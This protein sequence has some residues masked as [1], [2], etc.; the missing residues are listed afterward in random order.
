M[1][2]YTPIPARQGGPG[3]PVHLWPPIADTNLELPCGKCIGCRTD[4]A[5][6]WGN[7][8][9]HEAR[10][11]ATNSFITLTY[12][13]EHAPTNGL[14]APD[15]LTNFIKRLR[16]NAHRHGSLFDRDSSRNIRYLACGEY[17]GSTGRPHYHILAFNCGFSNP[18]RRATGLYE[19][20]GLTKTWGKG[21]A[22]YGPATPGAA[23]YIAKY[24]L[25]KQGLP[26][27]RRCQRW[28]ERPGHTDDTTGEWSPYLGPGLPDPQGPFLRMSQKPILG[29]GWLDTYGNDLKHGYLVINGQK[30][31]IPRSYT[32][33][34]KRNAPD[35]LAIMQARRFEQHLAQPRNRDNETP[36]RREAAA[37]IHEQR[38]K[39]ID[40]RNRAC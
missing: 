31:P 19:A 28:N 5:A 17:G 39:A 29:G 13:E 6:A 11:Y 1:A 20:E 34:I 24:S 27:W 4:R 14:L 21:I 10:L 33:Y 23:T 22:N 35:F 18:T 15:D 30:R 7:R 32:E 16:Q 9:Q 2:C 8:A 25:K 38:S 3:E 26:E 40:K 12:D 37:K 36:E